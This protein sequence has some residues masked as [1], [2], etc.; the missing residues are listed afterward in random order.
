MKMR[1]IVDGFTNSMLMSVLRNQAVIM[2]AL[3]NSGTLTTKNSAALMKS[4]VQID[5]EIDNIESLGEMA[6]AQM[7]R[8]VGKET[9][10]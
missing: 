4:A 3:S 9:E 6:I 5:T 2:R 7:E 1:S 10:Q 8:A